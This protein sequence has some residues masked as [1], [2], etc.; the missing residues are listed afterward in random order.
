MAVWA[1]NNIAAGWAKHT[2][3][4]VASGVI[5]RLLELG[6]SQQ[7]DTVKMQV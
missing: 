2:D 4:V 5:P 7:H 6:I 1:I 3:V